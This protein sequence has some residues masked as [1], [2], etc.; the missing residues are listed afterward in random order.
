MLWSM[1]DTTNKKEGTGN[2][3][4]FSQ[5]LKLADEI[6]AGRFNLSSRVN[7][8]GSKEAYDTLV[9]LTAD[10][11]IDVQKVLPIEEERKYLTELKK[12]NDIDFENF[13]SFIREKIPGIT[14]ID[15]GKYRLTFYDPKSRV[16]LAN[17]FLI[18]A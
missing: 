8:F 5:K 6:N 18:P 17:R 16:Y 9:A 10:G 15:A 3:A 13:D 2:S 11:R 1:Q 14:N 4:F 12:M 7:N